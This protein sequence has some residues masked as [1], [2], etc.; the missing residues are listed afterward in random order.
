[1]TS[2][3]SSA[4]LLG[5]IL[6]ALMLVLSLGVTPA[7]AD[8]KKDDKDKTG[9][10]VKSDNKSS[11]EEVSDSSELIVS[12][13][14]IAF[15]QAASYEGSLKNF[16]NELENKSKEKKDKADEDKKDY[17]E[18]ENKAH[19]AGDSVNEEKYGKL[20]NEANKAKDEAKKSED[21]HK[22]KKDEHK[23]KQEKYSESKIPSGATACKTPD[24]ALGFLPSSAAGSK[25]T[26]MKKA[27]REIFGQ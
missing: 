26:P 11:W 3:T 24:G 16:E 17:E 10:E 14:C 2:S 1:M 21:E 27:L 6:T 22:S 8:D 18:L 19:D 4:T 15:T 12:E 25:G 13:N 5:R 20:K 9:N 7:L 23:D